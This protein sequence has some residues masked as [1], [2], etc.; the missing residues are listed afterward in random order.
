MI[1]GKS[2]PN[3]QGRKTMKDNYSP[4]QPGM[5][6]GACVWAYLR[7]SGGPS[8]EQSV[9]Q[10]ENEILAYCKRYKL[11]LVKIFRDVAR[12]GGSVLSRDEFMAMIEQSED[13]SIR[14]QAILIWNFARFARDYNDSVFY[15]AT[16]HRRGVI[17]HS[18]TDQIPADDFAGR[19]VETVINLANEEKRRQTSRDV[20]RGLKS[21]VSKGFSPGTPPRGYIAIK[22][23]IGSRRDG[24]PRIVSKWE[25]DPVLS[26]YVKIAWQLRAQGKSYQEITHA[27]HGKLYTGINSWHGFFR[28]KAYLGI[29]KNG[30]LEIEDHHE[31]LI[32]WDLWEAVQKLFGPPREKKGQLNHPRRVGNPTIFSGFTYCIECGAMMT[33]STGKKKHPWLHY[34]CGRKDRHGVT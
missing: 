31:P 16:L 14:P 3:P 12:S 8:Q 13:E 34:I 19:I 10:Q 5:P 2:Y 4:P 21:L 7:D 6:A 1:A 32:T 24:L 29:G 25:P 33:H 11:N 28:N 20:K 22:V 17:V 30:D 26:E 9:D 18:L 23:T 15:K 27:T